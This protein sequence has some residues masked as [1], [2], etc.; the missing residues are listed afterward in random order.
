MFGGRRAGTSAAALKTAFQQFAQTPSGA[1]TDDSAGK[2]VQMKI[3]VGMGIRNLFRV[4][5]RKRIVGNDRA[6]NMT[7]QTCIRI[8]GIGI[9]VDTPVLLSEIA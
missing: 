8:T 7:Q 2:I 9:L 1:V 3:P 5:I 4:Y 6:G